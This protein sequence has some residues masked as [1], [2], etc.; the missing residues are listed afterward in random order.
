MYI[1]RIFAL[2]D[3]IMKGLNR[4]TSGDSDKGLGVGLGKSLERKKC[5]ITGFPDISIGT[6]HSYS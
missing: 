3:Q 2:I 1:I 6:G 4:N 5:P